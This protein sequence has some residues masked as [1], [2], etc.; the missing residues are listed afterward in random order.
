MMPYTK[1]LV[2]RLLAMRWQHPKPCKSMPRVVELQ[3][4]C[5]EAAK[6]IKALSAK[7]E[8]LEAKMGAWEAVL[9]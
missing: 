8:R 7:I 6:E 5:T 1:E 2:K 3:C 4:L 9:L